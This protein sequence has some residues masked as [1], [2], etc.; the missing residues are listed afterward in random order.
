MHNTRPVP[1]D[2]KQPQTHTPQA[3]PDK[4]T[5]SNQLH[6]GN[7]LPCIQLHNSKSVP[8]CQW[9][10]RTT[11]NT[12]RLQIVGIRDWDYYASPPANQQQRRHV[13]GVTKAD[14]QSRQSGKAH[15]QSSKADS[16]DTGRAKQVTKAS[17]PHSVILSS[18]PA[19]IPFNPLCAFNAIPCP[20][21]IP[22]C[23][24]RAPLNHG[25]NGR[26]MA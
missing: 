12:N 11:I 5:A 8:T 18:P 20:P 9:S 21:V 3:N 1:T 13:S 10:K 24:A 6:V 4:N 26:L 22:Y 16:A 25:V 2:T 23:S 7:R 14:Q 19:S 15:Q 17:K